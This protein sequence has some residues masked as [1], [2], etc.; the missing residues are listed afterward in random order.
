MQVVI[1]AAGKGTRLHPVTE[2]RSKAMAPVAGKPMIGRV[3]D[4]FTTQEISNF[5]VIISPDDLEIRHYFAQQ[6]S[7]KGM[8]Q[9]VEQTERLGMANALGLAADQIR[10]DFILS[11]CDNLVP[12]SHIHDLL[13]TFDKAKLCQTNSRAVLSL[14]GIDRANVSSTGVVKLRDGAVWGIVEKPKPEE[15]PSN[16]SSLSRS[17]F[18]V[19]R[20]NSG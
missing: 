5:I 13:T 15:A 12:A 9:F 8:I 4:M 17:K 18:Q 10:G 2:T 6:A 3:M 16:I 20:E 19:L 1:L 14:M 11:A 7:A